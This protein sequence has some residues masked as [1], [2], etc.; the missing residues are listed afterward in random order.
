MKGHKERKWQT[1][2]GETEQQG[3]RQAII[4]TDKEFEK[5]KKTGRQT[6]RMRENNI[7]IK[8]DNENRK[9]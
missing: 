8:T 9:E 2:R 6:S 5:Q 1:E 4:P 7:E 3:K